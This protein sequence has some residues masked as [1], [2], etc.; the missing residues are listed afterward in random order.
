MNTT[1]INLSIPGKFIATL[2][3]SLPVSW[4]PQLIRISTR[5]K[6]IPRGI[7]VCDFA[8]RITELIHITVYVSIRIVV[9]IESGALKAVTD[10]IAFIREP[11]RR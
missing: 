1:L 7:R 4:T 11:L 6:L 2:H 8:Q 5:A 9:T 10:S 3:K